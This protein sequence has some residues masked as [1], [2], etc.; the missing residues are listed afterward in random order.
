[1]RNTRLACANDAQS[2]GLRL[3]SGS[4]D[5]SVGFT[6]T[7]LVRIKTGKV[8]FFYVRFQSCRSV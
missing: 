7:A 6:T 4:E 1:M 3:N 8:K 5:I 2:E